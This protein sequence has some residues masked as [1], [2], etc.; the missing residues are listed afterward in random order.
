M[1]TV[2]YGDIVPQNN[3][4]KIL[5]IFT[6]M[7][8]CGVFGYSLNIIGVIIND[9]FLQDLEIDKKLAIINK[10]MTKKNI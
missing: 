3:N 8:A 6:M 2:G 5:C 10:F 1:I 4:E 7:V 9:F